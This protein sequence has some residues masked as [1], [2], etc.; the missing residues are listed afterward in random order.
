MVDVHHVVQGIVTDYRLNT[1]ESVLWDIYEL[2]TLFS[3]R[4]KIISDAPISSL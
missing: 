2:T 1:Y 4:A 3:I